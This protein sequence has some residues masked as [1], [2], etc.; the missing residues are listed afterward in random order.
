MKPSRKE[1]AEALT[2]KG[3]VFE[4][5]EDEVWGRSWYVFLNSPP[6]LSCVLYASEAADE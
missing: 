5:Y 2:A 3:E 6:S 4:L 1:V